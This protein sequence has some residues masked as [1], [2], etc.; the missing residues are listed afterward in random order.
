MGYFCARVVLHGAPESD[1]EAVHALM[2]AEGFHLAF[3]KAETRYGMPEATYWK[4]ADVSLPTEEAAVRRALSRSKYPLGDGTEKPGTS[5][6]FLI[7]P[8]VAYTHVGLR[9]RKAAR[10]LSEVL[11]KKGA[12]PVP[13]KK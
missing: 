6:F 5:A 3:R 9:R 12:K 13:A 7:G 2:K 8:S 11:G 10:K 1:Y 4:K